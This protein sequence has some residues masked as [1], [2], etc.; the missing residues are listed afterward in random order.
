MKNG[1]QTMKIV[2][3]FEVWCANVDMLSQHKFQELRFRVRQAQPMVTAISEVKPKSFKSDIQFVEYNLRGYEMIAANLSRESKSRG[4]ILYIKDTLKYIT[5]DME[6]QNLEEAILCEIELEKNNKLLLWLMYRGPRSSEENLRN[7][8]KL[9]EEVSQS[10]F[11]HVLLMGDY[12]IPGIDWEWNNT[13]GSV[14]S[15]EFRFLETVRDC[16][17]YQH[18]TAPTRG[19]GSD[20]PSILDLSFTN[21]E[22]MV[23]DNNG[24]AYR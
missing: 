2:N 23:E 10:K 22:G 7:M 15:L 14:K 12:N 18:V 4:M 5:S 3:K 20:K 19:R 24:L 8:C 9:M 6:I 17:L 16:Y 1:D 11:S 21:E 13:Q